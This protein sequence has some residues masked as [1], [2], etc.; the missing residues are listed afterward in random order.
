MNFRAS[1][2]ACSRG[3]FPVR[4]CGCRFPS[5]ASRSQVAAGRYGRQVSSPGNYG[6]RCSASDS[7]GR[8]CRTA[9]GC[10]RHF[11]VRRELR[12][13]FWDRVGRH[14]RAPPIACLPH[15]AVNPRAALGL[16]SGYSDPVWSAHQGYVPSPQLALFDCARRPG[17]GFHSGFAQTRPYL[18]GVDPLTSRGPYRQIDSL[19][20]G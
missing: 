4:I 10:G 13:P 19:Q 11:L 6:R 12:A 2:S 7:C 9:E 18:C 1:W 17:G 16:R 3:V 20:D 8:H 14:F 5:G 15:S